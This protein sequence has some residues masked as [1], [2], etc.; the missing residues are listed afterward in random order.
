MP[1]LVKIAWVLAL[2]EVDDKAEDGETGELL[3]LIEQSC[4]ERRRIASKDLG[5]R[6]LILLEVLVVASGRSTLPKA[7]AGL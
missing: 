2:L 3:N 1:E 5:P 7:R 6:R 4:K